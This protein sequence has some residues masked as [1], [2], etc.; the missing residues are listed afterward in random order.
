MIYSITDRGKA[1]VDA[2]SDPE[3]RKYSPEGEIIWPTEDMGCQAN[4][5]CLLTFYEG[6]TF[7]YNPM[8]EEYSNVPP[9]M[10]RVLERLG[11]LRHEGQEIFR[12]QV[13]YQ[14]RVEM[15]RRRKRFF[16]DG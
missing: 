7:D 6:E 16:G 11:Y 1:F 13:R 4:A 12:E 5:L 2:V 3:G 15:S 10:V 14:K 8:L 9:L